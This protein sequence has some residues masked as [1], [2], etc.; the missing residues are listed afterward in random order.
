MK[1]AYLLGTIASVFVAIPFA[2]PA[3]TGGTAA[4]TESAPTNELSEITVTARR[5]QENLEQV[6]AS[7]QAVTGEDLSSAGVRK[8]TDITSLVSGLVF[9][10]IGGNQQELSLRGSTNR[11]GGTSGVGV[12]QDGVAL[13]I[14]QLTLGA[15]D[16]ARVEVAK[17]P[18]ATL[19]GRGTQGGAIN[20]VTNDPTPYYEGSMEIGGGGSTVNDEKLWHALAIVSGPLA[21]DSLLGRLVVSEEERDGWAYDPVTG[22]RGLGYDRQFVRGKVKW[23][24]NDSFDLVVMA[25][26]MHDNPT[27]G[28]TYF[29]PPP[30]S[31]S[32]YPL[33]IDSRPV[34]GCIPCPVDFGKN[35]WDTRFTIKPTGLSQDA[36]FNVEANWRTDIGK[37]TSMSS[38]SHTDT[39]SLLD[40]DGTQ[41]PLVQTQY[42][43]VVERM[44]EEL[45]L[46]GGDRLKYVTGAYWLRTLS[47]ADSLL[48]A[49]PGSILYDGAGSYAVPSPLGTATSLTPSDT[50][51]TSYSVFGQLGFDFTERFNVTGGVRLQRDQFNGTTE[52]IVT[53]VNGSQVQTGPFYRTADFDGWAGNLV[54]TYHFNPDMLVY[55]SYGRGN[56][57]GGLNGGSTAVVADTPFGQEKV[58]SFEVGFKGEMLD[59]RLRTNLTIFD[60]QYQG[61]QLQR[62][63]IVQIFPLP[64]PGTLTS[65]TTNAAS[66]RADGADLDIAY[67]LTR[68]L[69]FSLSYTNYLDAKIGRYTL[70]AGTPLT[71]D[72]S[73][74]PLW[75]SPRNSGT[76]ALSWSDDVG[77]GRLSI[78]PYVYFSSQYANDYFTPPTPGLP[79]QLAPTQAYHTLNFTTSY[80]WGNW[81][82]SAWGHNL[83]R[84]QYIVAAELNQYNQLPLGNAGE[85]PTY[86]ITVKR[87]FGR[88]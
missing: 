49:G 33:F 38:Y 80:A 68:T 56:K 75:R 61:L 35:I 18:Q 22:W 50:N 41:Y 59:H 60:A 42:P 32:I 20:W 19:Y 34:V 52:T 48:T 40:A 51:L 88:H 86:E 4:E 82:V 45:R 36:S 43:G 7:V 47:G 12:F 70:V 10:S 66:A 28:T 37:L 3:A 79:V 63:Q 83:L 46:A 30:G 17:G 57:P 5:Q 58:N 6:P 26:Y 69:R 11:I 81:E 25:A 53:R 13:D 24:A 21:G 31:P 27:Q 65:L 71:G 85:P 9:Q 54:S 14:T 55:A 78:E 44:S 74:Q 15:I 2:A 29:P 8:M 73:G 1:R 77:P 39:N 72:L 87:F 23:L 16:V 67:L 62:T 76:A 64:A 84:E